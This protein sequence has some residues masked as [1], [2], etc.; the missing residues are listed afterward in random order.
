MV[1]PASTRSWVSIVT[2]FTCQ[3]QLAISGFWYISFAMLTNLNKIDSLKEVLET[4]NKISLNPT[5][6]IVRSIVSTLFMDVDELKAYVS[7]PALMSVGSSL[8]GQCFGDGLELS[9][10]YQNRRYA[11]SRSVGGSAGLSVFNVVVGS[12]VSE[13]D[14]VTIAGFKATSVTVASLESQTLLNVCSIETA[15]DLWSFSSDGSR[16]TVHVPA[17]CKNRATL[18]GAYVQCI[19]GDE[20]L[21]MMLCLHDGRIRRVLRTATDTLD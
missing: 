11:L 13:P 6:M 7:E 21:P 1:A 5:E 2:D 17:S 20:H 14:S 16:I 19:D 3:L 4:F 12:V 9:V 10:V 8:T 15:C 18:F